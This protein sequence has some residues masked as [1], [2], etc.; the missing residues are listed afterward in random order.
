MLPVA[1]FTVAA[2][3]FF[4]YQI[5]DP[6]QRIV[7]ATV[8]LIVVALLFRY[9][10][11]Y[12]LLVFIVLFP[13][14]SGISLGSTNAV[15]ITLIVLTWLIRAHSRKERILERSPYDKVVIIFI[16][17]Y[18]NSFLNVDSAENVRFG[19]IKF[20][21]ALTAIAFFYL[22]VRFVR[23]ER[24]LEVVTRT[25]GLGAV[26]LF[27]TG[28]F[29]LFFPGKTIIP[30]WIGLKRPMMELGSGAHIRVG[31]AV[32]SHS[33]I[34]DYACLAILL[35]AY[36][37]R[38]AVNPIPKLIWGSAFTV[39]ICVLLATANRGAFVS[40]VVGLLYLGYLFRREISFV[41]LVGVASLL[42]A[43]FFTTTYFLHTYTPAASIDKRL[44]NTEFEGITPDNRVGAWWPAF[45][46]A[47]EKPIL[48]RGPYY[49]IAPGLDKL[50]WPHNAYI[51]HFYTIG[52]FGVL[53]FIVIQVMLFFRSRRWARRRV[54]KKTL[55]DTMIIVFHAQLTMNILQLMRT[56]YQRDDV[57]PYI[58][59]M[60]YGLI[61]ATERILERRQL[62]QEIPSSPEPA[63]SPRVAAVG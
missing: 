16:V 43:L 63:E 25:I 59:W 11:L 56:D 8:A 42:V 30:G 17:C 45:K 55:A 19:L 27:L 18:I 51:F 15:L 53:S 31:G 33:V 12:A 13:F 61:V 21:T 58:V 22:L 46:L 37:F 54:S 50:A 5:A 32:G 41:K 52:I 34:S 23:T 14:P 40:L 10:M 3:L 36:Y 39:T 6:N 9:Q 28:F 48:G 47:L 35:Q 57:Y 2:A 7:K 24:D 62:A 44:L 49:A 60:L 38:K 26:L 4:G 29:E 1:I 20:W